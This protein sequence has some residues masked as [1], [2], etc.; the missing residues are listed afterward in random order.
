MGWR[1]KAIGFLLGLLTRRPQFMVLGLLL[2]HLYDMGLF[3][4]R[5]RAEAMPPPAGLDAAY[6]S[7]GLSP[8]ASDADLEQAYRR[9]IS[10][11][12]P[13]RVA[14]AAS[15][16]RELAETRAREINTAYEAIRR[17]RHRDA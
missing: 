6:A 16:I 9:R 2:G 14:N 3:T 17:D 13:D 10:E 7:L 1:G 12:H 4:N 8:D 5:P 15:E 11:Y